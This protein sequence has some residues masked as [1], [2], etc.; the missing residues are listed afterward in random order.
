MTFVGRKDPALGAEQRVLVESNLFDVTLELYGSSITVH[1]ER[2]MRPPIPIAS[3]QQLQE[4]L[5]Q[6]QRDCRKVLS[7]VESD[8]S[9]DTPTA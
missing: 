7:E 6:D 4:M 3:L 5:N 1:F 2:F 9:N 8:F